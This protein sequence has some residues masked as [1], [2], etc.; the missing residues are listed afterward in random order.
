MW[1]RS[2]GTIEP[3][4]AARHGGIVTCGQ[5]VTSDAIAAGIGVHG[6][7]VRLSTSLHEC[8]TGTTAI[9]GTTAGIIVTDPSRLRSNPMPA[10]YDAG[11]GFRSHLSALA[12]PAPPFHRWRRRGG[13]SLCL[14]VLIKK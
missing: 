10:Q 7:G 1:K 12:R 14:L 9:I 6:Y 3:A 2:T 5:A 13:A 8:T 11:I 4:A